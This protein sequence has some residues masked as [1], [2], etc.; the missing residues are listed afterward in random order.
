M[1]NSVKDYRRPP[2][3]LFPT[4]FYIFSGQMNMNISD[5]FVI[6]QYLNSKFSIKR[7]LCFSILILF[8]LSQS[9][10]SHP[11]PPPLPILPIPSSQQLSWQLSEMALFLHFGPN[12]FTDSEWGSGHADPSVFN[13]TLLNATQWVNVAKDSGFSRV[14]LTAKHHDGFCL[15][16]SEYTDYSVKSSPWKNGTGDVVGELAQA[17]KFAGVQLGL[18]L[19][20]WDRHEATYGKTLDYNE[21]YLAQ[22]TELLTR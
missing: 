21:H 17:A 15:W 2:S 5:K 6:T 16:P 10:S 14:I 8:L 9:S 1:S 4:I 20:P 13:P 19:S 3:V 22:M 7:N 18:Y 12:T 11:N